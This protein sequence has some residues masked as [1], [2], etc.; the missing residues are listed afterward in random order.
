[1][2]QAGFELAS[3]ESERSYSYALDRAAKEIGLL[4]NYR[5]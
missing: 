5:G 2:T 1:M 4:A 3:P